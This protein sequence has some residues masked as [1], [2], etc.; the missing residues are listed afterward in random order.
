MALVFERLRNIQIPIANGMIEIRP[1][2][3]AEVPRLWEIESA[4]E[5]RG[6]LGSLRTPQDEWISTI[7]ATAR[8][9]ERRHLCLATVDTARNE[10]VGSAALSRPALLAQ[11]CELRIVL[12]PQRLRQGIGRRVARL[13]IDEAW[14]IGESAVVAETHPGNERAL[15]L[16]EALGFIEGGTVQS[17]DW[18]SGFRRFRLA[19]P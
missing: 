10:V 1:P 16:L 11:E 18:R 2:T 5:V 4:P 14:R 3:G 15:G 17:D 13:L 19:R 7:G 6:F 9:L 8:D 12:D